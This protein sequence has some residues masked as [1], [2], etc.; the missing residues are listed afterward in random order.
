MY[1]LHNKEHCFHFDVPDLEY[2]CST[3]DAP[4]ILVDRYPYSGKSLT[5]VPWLLGVL[6]ML[7]TIVTLVNILLFGFITV[8]E[9]EFSS[10]SVSIYIV[11]YMAAV[12]FYWLQFFVYSSDLKDLTRY[13][14]HLYI[15]SQYVFG[16]AGL[17]MILISIWVREP[18]NNLG[19][20]FFGVSLMAPLPL[21]FFYYHA[22]I[23]NKPV[24]NNT[25]I[26]KQS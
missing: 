18:L 7:F 21:C 4:W 12:S 13:Y 1:A 11:V 20:V 22:Y 26:I 19:L 5:G 17:F 14:L 8:R 23:E 6:T 24:I 9:D 16:L 25:T 10:L 3:C 2:R 15:M